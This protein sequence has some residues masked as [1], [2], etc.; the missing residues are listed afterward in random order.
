MKRILVIRQH[1]QLG[2]MLC[3]V[4]LLRALRQRYPSSSITLVT[5]PVNDAIMQHHPLVDEVLLYDKSWWL[6]VLKFVLALR[7]RHYDLSVVPVTVSLSFTSDLLSV[8]SGARHRVGASALNGI[9]N[10]SAFCHTIR[11]TPDWRGEAHRHQTLRNLDILK[12]AGFTTEQ[13]EHSVGITQKEEAEAKAMLAEL[14]KTHSLIIGFHPGAGKPENRWPAE[15]F[16]E[17]VNRLHQDYQ[18][19]IVVTCGP[20]DEEPFAQMMKNLQVPF[21]A[22]ERKPLR[23]VAAVINE[24]DLYVTNDTGVLHVAGGTKANVLAL[25]G[26]TDPLQWAPIGRKNRY[27]AGKDG[28]MSSIVIDDVYSMIEIILAE[29]G[30]RR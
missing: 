12:P 9:E 3:A 30:K 16:A 10:P 2:D 1:D 5:S 18:A 17:L 4:P 25:F 20:M 29:A 14:W 19:G 26:P 6:G 28:T 24:L 22:I 23:T 13:L 21:L 11:A 8:F 27:I 15:R 7:A